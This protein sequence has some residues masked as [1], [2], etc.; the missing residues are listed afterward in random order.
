M[1]DPSF[2]DAVY[3]IA[4]INPLDELHAQAA[5]VDDRAGLVTTDAVLGE[6]LAYF[7]G[8]GA[9]D[10]VLAVSVV[11]RAIANPHVTVIHKDAALF[12]A[13]LSLYRAR[14]DKGYSLVDCMSMVVC[15]DRQIQAVLTHDRH[16]EQEGFAIL[17]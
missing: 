8:R 11:D 14:L 9:Y 4:L 17:L 2:A 1:D 3:Y 13:G 16:F 6:V 7:S 5:G 12:F 10:R 15:R